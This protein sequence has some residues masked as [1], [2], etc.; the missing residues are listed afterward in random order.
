MSPRDSDEWDAGTDTSEN[1]APYAITQVKWSQDTKILH[2]LLLRGNLR[3]YQQSGLEWLASLHNNK[4][5]GILA[6]EMGLGCV[7]TLRI[8]VRF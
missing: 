7:F 4:M 1:M 8:F 3:P 2:P 6:D 5:N